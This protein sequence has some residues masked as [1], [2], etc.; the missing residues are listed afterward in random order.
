M[1]PGL[2]GAVTSWAVS[3]MHD[4]IGYLL[5]EMDSG[6]GVLA[7]RIMRWDGTPVLWLLLYHD[8][9]VIMG[10]IASLIT[11]LTIVYSTVY[12]DADQRKH[13]SSALRDRWIPHTKGQL[14]GKCFHLMTSSWHSREL[15]WLCS[16]CVI[17]RGGN[18]SCI[19]CVWVAGKMATAFDSGCWA[20]FS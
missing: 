13:Q 19:Y 20:W 6:S 10:V 18:V 3:S 1:G 11:S 15:W 7:G 8:D 12:S 4:W 2:S 9:D 17:C 14:R 5:S 16:W